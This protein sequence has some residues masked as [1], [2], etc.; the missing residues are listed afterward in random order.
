[1]RK[2]TI[3]YYK[4]MK[5]REENLQYLYDTFDVIELDD[6]SQD[7]TES[8]GRA[9]IL[10]A[11]LGYVVDQSKIDRCIRL[12]AIGSNTTGH[13]HIDVKY[14][15]SKGIAVITL[16]DK[17]SFLNKI[18]PTAELTW[19]L[20]VAITRNLLPATKSVGAGQWD[21]RPFG[22]RKMLSRMSIGIVGLGRLGYKVAHYGLKFGMEVKYYDP[23]VSSGYPGLKKIESLD[24]LVAESDV[25]SVHVPHE[26]DTEW[27]FSENVFQNFKDGSYFIN[28]SRGE[29]V[30]HQA[31]LNS[32]K[33]GK[34]AGAA[35]DV[36]EDEFQSDFQSKMVL[37]DLWKFSQ[38]H[39]N[40]IITPHIAGSTYDAWFETER[41]TLETLKNILNGTKLMHENLP[42]MQGVAWAIIPGR[43][44]SK[45][46]TLKNM[47]KLNGKPL[48]E[49]SISAAFASKMISNTICS[50]D[51]K[52]IASYCRERKIEVQQ[53]PDFLSTDNVSTVDVLLYVVQE[54]VKHQKKLPEFIVLLE[55]T[56][57]FVTTRQIEQC[58]STLSADNTADSA[59]TVTKVSSNSHAYN[60]RYHDENGSNFLYIQERNVCINKQLKPEFFIHGNVRVIRTESLIKTGSL[61]GERSIP[62]EISRF[63]A[64]DVDG[65]EDMTLAE[66]MIKA[67]IIKVN[68]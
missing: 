55:P 26:P 49:Y 16:K 4:I 53:R 33:S 65:P 5:Y 27:L 54:I 45:S 10:L 38:N 42:V 39:S 2:P 3:I 25:V 23:H 18:T 9:E 36:F 28:T 1:M 24:R 64:M 59:Q 56:S 57:P 46:I 62:I 7:D 44:G 15:K 52:I 21:R 68:K 66:S 48:I 34:I 30:N 37:H 40:V 43:G 11:P 17:K 60:Q 67:G 13:P 6:P 32:L 22:G 29:L 51:S 47:A 12:K 63:D 19:G 61:F 35:I 58:I 14:A 31:L 8:L 41:Y 50:T 20:I